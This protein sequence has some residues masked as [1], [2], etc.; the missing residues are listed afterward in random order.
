[1]RRRRDGH[2]LGRDIEPD[3]AALLVGGREPLGHVGHRR[4]IEVHRRAGLLAD[5]QHRAR[6]HVARREIAERV[7]PLHEALA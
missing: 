3:L 2:R 7:E 1:V 4:R 6:D 5:L